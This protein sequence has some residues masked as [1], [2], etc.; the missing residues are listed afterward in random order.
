MRKKGIRMTKKNKEIVI[1]LLLTKK[2]SNEVPKLTVTGLQK[3]ATKLRERNRQIEDLAAAQKEE[4]TAMLNVVKQERID[5]EKKGHF[6]K[7]CLVESETEQTVKVQFAN[8]FS[9]IDISNEEILRECLGGLFDELYV[10]ET[11]VRI[12]DD[13]SPQMLKDK[14]GEEMYT[15]LFKEEKFIGHRDEFME[16]RARLR[17]TLNDKTNNVI[18]QLI[19]QCQSKPSTN[20]N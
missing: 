9:K 4:E 7:C 15:L 13:I 14:L 17:L 16:V 11:I 20:Y 6:F 19:N 2:N 10:P 18:D 8:K 12:R 3:L 5:A 1:P